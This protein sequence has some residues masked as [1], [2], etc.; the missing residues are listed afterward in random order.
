[1]MACVLLDT[2][3]VSELMRVRPEQAVLDW[4]VERTADQF[5]VSVVTQAE[6]LLGVSL[7]PAG[8]RRNALASAAMEMFEQDFAG[9][10]LPFDASCAPH[11]AAIV[12]A[13]RRAGHATSA[14]DAMIAA[15]ALSRGYV[16]A[17]RN[18]KDFLHVEGLILCNP[19][20]G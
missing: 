11:Y 14:E 1:M 12:A 13:R 17:T 20:R 4:F 19:W 10:C 7:L 9:R 6:I 8:A 3:V 15:I 18:T 2:N 16:L 5:Y